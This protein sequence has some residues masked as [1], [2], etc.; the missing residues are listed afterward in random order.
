MGAEVEGGGWE[1]GWVFGGEFGLHGDGGVEGGDREV[2]LAEG[3]DGVGWNSAGGA[4][5]GGGFAWG[6]DD[7]A[8]FGEVT[9]E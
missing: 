3:V 6:E 4:G 2:E 9:F 8:I 5:A 1:V 7:E